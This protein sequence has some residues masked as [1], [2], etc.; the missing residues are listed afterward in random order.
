MEQ[1]TGI[2]PALSAWEAEVLPLNYIC[3]KQSRTHGAS[4][5]GGIRLF[6]TYIILVF[7]RFV[8]SSRGDSP[9]FDF[10]YFYS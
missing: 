1:I 2:E 6:S 7:R 5:D 10:F 4:S 3:I 9:E 8:N